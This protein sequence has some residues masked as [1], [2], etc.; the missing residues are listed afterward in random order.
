MPSS[1]NEN[2]CVAHAAHTWAQN[3]L[4]SNKT[5]VCTDCGDIRPM[6]D[7][8]GN[9]CYI[10]YAGLTSGFIGTTFRL[11]KGEHHA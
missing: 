5:C 6:S 4:S 2:Y 11:N 7:L 8:S 3:G 10:K 9:P 1:G